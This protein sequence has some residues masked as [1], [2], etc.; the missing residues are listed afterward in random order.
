MKIL[1]RQQVQEKTGI[2][3]TQLYE[4]MAKGKFPNSIKLGGSRSVGW[5]E[6]SIDE[7]IEAQIAASRKGAA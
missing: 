6:N 5:L 4:L 3:R 2:G 7:W 1:R